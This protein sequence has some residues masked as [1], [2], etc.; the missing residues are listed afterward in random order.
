MKNQMFPKL[1]LTFCL[2]LLS[3]TISSAQSSKWKFNFK[4]AK[5]TTELSKIMDNPKANIVRS[6]E[7][8]KKYVKLTP[9]LSKVFAKKGLLKKVTSTMKFNK[10]GL[11]TFSYD[12]IAKVYPNNYK[13]ILAEI[14]LGLGFELEPLAADYNGYS[15]AG[16]GD[17]EKTTNHICIGD[18]C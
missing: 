17:C 3:F 16:V 7:D 15:C 2:A 11:R 9:S 14:T 4:A 1:I 8:F 10:R 18:N 12:A 6:V 13:T 5:T